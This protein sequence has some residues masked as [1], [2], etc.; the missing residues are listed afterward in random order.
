MIL[1]LLGKALIEN[2]VGALKHHLEKKQAIRNIEIAL[3][4]A[5]KKPS[6]SEMPNIQVARKSI[7]AGKDIK[8]GDIFT[9]N[10]LAIKRPG[11]GI[12]PM[13]WDEVIGTFASRNYSEDDLI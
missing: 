9:K 3:G 8:K 13:K 1:N 4:S 6:N 10:N 7:V 11:N 5:E 12:S 2:S